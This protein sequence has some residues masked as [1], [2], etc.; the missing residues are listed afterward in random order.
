MGTTIAA[1][2]L[3][4]QVQAK[5]ALHFKNTEINQK[6][7]NKCPTIKR[8]LFFPTLYL[9]HGILQ[10]MWASSSTEC[11]PNIKF[12]EETLDLPCG[13]KI[14]MHWASHIEDRQLEKKKTIVILVPGLTASAQEPYMKNI[15]T[16]ALNNG[17]E[18]VVFHNRGNTVE[19]TLPKT[20]F[21]DPI[22]DF[23]F[24][25]DYVK[26]KYPSHTI[27]AIGHSYGANALVNYLGKYK[28][29]HPIKAAAS[30]A[31]PFDLI[32]AATGNLDTMFDKYLAQSLQTWAKK[33]EAVLAKAP[34]HLNLEYDRAMVVKSIVLFDEYITRR[35]MGFS[36]S[37][38]YYESI[39]S[40]KRLK[41]I[42]IPLLCMQA[43]DD[44]ILHHSSIPVDECVSNENITLL[45]TNSGGHVQW[46]EG[47][48]KPKRWFPKPTVEFLNAC[49]D[50]IT[51]RRKNVY[52][53][54]V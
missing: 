4:P 7:L 23:K 5:F 45:V 6:R 17:Y 27:F 22:D 18:V 44:P 53:K 42:N 34:K 25:V 36:N 32:K 20:G 1:S 12:A 51:E 41:N 52:A 46:F 43:K 14:G 47:F 29:Q 24:A 33:N 16:E 3:Y 35:I 48:F 50:E 54:S 38:E 8:G 2:L 15:A 31:N 37:N 39:S 10:A 26:S 19:M 9:G 11:D 30:I 13:G 40:T 28:D 21:L 49:Y